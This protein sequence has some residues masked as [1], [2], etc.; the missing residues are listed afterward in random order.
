[1]CLYFYFLKFYD[2]NKNDIAFGPLGIHTN[3]QNKK[4]KNQ[5][6]ANGILRLTTEMPNV[7]D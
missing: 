7:D 6:P 2:P 5:Q 1:M 4:K 3:K